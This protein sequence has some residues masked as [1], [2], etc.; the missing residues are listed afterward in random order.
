MSDIN[1]EKDIGFMKV[2]LR[3]AIKG[4]GLTSPNPAVGCIIVKGG[5]IISKGYH[6]SAGS[7]HAEIEAITNARTRSLKGS[8]L[9]VTLEPCSTHGRTPPCAD[10]I[11]DAGINRVVYGSNDPNP[12]H[13]GKS[14]RLLKRGG[15]NVTEGVLQ[16]SCS[17]LIRPFEKYITTGLPWVLAKAGMSIDGRLTRPANE[18]QWLTCK[19][20]LADAQKVRGEVDAII[21]GAGT[22]RADDPKLTIR[23]SK[24]L[25][26]GKLQPWR[27][28]LTRSGNLSDKSKVF[29]DRFTDRTILYKRK[30]LKAILK[31][32]AGKYNCMNVMIEGG[33]KLLG[34]AF[35]KGLVD[36]VCFYIAPII[37]GNK[38]TP[39]ADIAF[40][41]SAQLSDTTVKRIGE[42]LRIRGLVR[43]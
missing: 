40:P 28:I 20:S 43:D 21:V 23:D 33:G 35:R 29:T 5:K 22:V 27:V 38:C 2:A 34:E 6:R 15:I 39:V 36:E 24:I 4:K 9:Y 7:P 1:D 13:R 10:S 30:S 16:E 32:L 8:T 37:C 41:S 31:D 25:K 26:R 18:S 3:E 42:D 12:V 19:E 11:I 17:K 14:K